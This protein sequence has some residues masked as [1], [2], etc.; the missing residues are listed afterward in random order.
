M[1]KSIFAFLIIMLLNVSLFGQKHRFSFTSGR[2]IVGSFTPI[3]IQ[4]DWYCFGEIP[5]LSIDQR[6]SHFDRL[7]ASA[8]YSYGITDRWRITAGYRYN[9]K[10]TGFTF[11]EFYAQTNVTNSG[12]ISIWYAHQG[13]LL[14]AEYQFLNKKRVKMGVSA[15]LNPEKYKTEEIGGR[16]NVPVTYTNLG[17]IVGMNIDVKIWRFL[18]LQINPF[19]EMGLT[20]YKRGKGI[21]NQKTTYRPYGFGYQV[22]L[23]FGF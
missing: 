16:Q 12:Y 20:D 17:G 14:G 5:E 15:L 21:L 2:E 19:A 13:Y 1:I 3:D 8:T 6:L 7:S 11:T 9:E 10:G 18:S 22:G 4:T 23:G